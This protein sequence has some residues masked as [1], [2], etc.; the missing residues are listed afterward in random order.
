MGLALIGA[1]LAGSSCAED[2]PLRFKQER[3]SSPLQAL[4]AAEFATLGDPLFNLVLK[5]K[6]HVTKLSEIESLLQPEIAKRA[7][8]VVDERIAD[9]SRPSS[10]RAVIAFEGKNGEESLHGNVM[11]SIAFS[12]ESFPD[13][14]RSIEAWGWD[15][16]RGRYNYYKMDGTGTPDGARMWKFRG[17]SEDADLL[18]PNERK[19]T[20]FA[21][22]VNG[23]PIMKELFLPWNNWHSLSFGVT[24]LDE[25]APSRWP[26][27]GAERFKKTLRQAEELEAS[28]M[29]GTIRRFNGSRINR[30]IKRRDDTGDRATSAEGFQTILEGRRLLRPLFE[31]TEVNLVSSRDKSGSHPFNPPTD[32]IPAKKI[33][34]PGTLFLN[35]PLIGGGQGGTRGLGITD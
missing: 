32:F 26:V 30:A 21:C 34:W 9:P 24:Y 19:G 10:R 18:R 2:I 7:T 17:T 16:H 25:D 4:S 29:V 31:T 22:H 12:S 14:A 33:R 35:A 8:F 13:S 3:D 5:D 15:N 11:L 27:A 23:A 1:P 20:C 6:S 28:F